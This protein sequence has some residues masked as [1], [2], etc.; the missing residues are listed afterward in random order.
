MKNNL[1]LISMK[2]AA[3]QGDAEA[4]FIL[5]S[6]Y[7]EGKGGSVDKAEAVKCFLKS[8]EQ[9]HTEAQFAL[10]RCHDN[11][12]GVVRDAVEA[13]K[14]FLLAGTYGNEPT[15]VLRGRLVAKMTAEQI[16]EAR[17]RVK[18]WRQEKARSRAI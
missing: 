3:E 10:G 4:Q 1:R 7:Y 2:E 8:A 9:G 12:E 11:G 14:W 13:Y 18:T 5:G 17:E 15:G 16:A 6:Y